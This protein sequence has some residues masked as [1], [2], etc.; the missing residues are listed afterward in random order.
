MKRLSLIFIVLFIGLAAYA[1]T[2]SSNAYSIDEIPNVPDSL[3]Y[4]AK[5]GD[6]FSQCLLGFNSYSRA[7]SKNE[8]QYYQKAVYWFRKAAEQGDDSAQ[9]M[10]GWCY[11]YGRGI[12]QNYT[13]AVYWFRKEAEQGDDS[14]QYMLGRCYYYGRGI[15][16]NYTEA[17]NWYRKAAEKDYAKGQW[18]LG[19]CY[20]Y[21]RGV[22]KSYADA[23]SWYQKDA[24]KEY[25]SAQ[26]TLGC[27][28]EWGG[29]EL[30]VVML[31]L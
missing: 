8:P 19:L 14:A 9:G 30:N 11:Y 16:Q 22:D 2:L 26:N 3:E 18:N 13:E 31:M 6:I 4:K 1:E 27:C 29:R 15:E 24:D 25:A 28:Y 7:L 12:E 21:G 20:Y 17:V 10:L 5:S 23:V